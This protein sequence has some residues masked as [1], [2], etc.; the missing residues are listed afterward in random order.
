M[1][2]IKRGALLFDTDFLIVARLFWEQ[3]RYRFTD[4]GLDAVFDAVVQR[5]A[6]T[7]YRCWPVSPE[8]VRAYVRER[9]RERAHPKLIDMEL[10]TLQSII[11]FVD[12]IND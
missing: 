6:R 3:Y 12:G 5:L 11:S 10:R 2:P 8:A 9:G 1:Q 4:I 7:F